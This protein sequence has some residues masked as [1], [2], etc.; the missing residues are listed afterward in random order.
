MKKQSGMDTNEFFDR[1]YSQDS[2][3]RGFSVYNSEGNVTYKAEVERMVY[4]L[5]QELYPTT[6]PTPALPVKEEAAPQ[7]KPA[8]AK[9]AGKKNAPAAIILIANLIFLAIVAI[10]CFDV[11]GKIGC[12]IAPFYK[13]AAGAC[14]PVSIL[15]GLF[16]QLGLPSQLDYSVQAD[17]VDKIFLIV[18]AVTGALT[19]VFALWQ[20][21][22]SIVCLAQKK[23]K[24]IRFGWR[25]FL[26]L[27]FLFGVLLSV[28]A[29]K[30]QIGFGDL[31]S[32]ILPKDLGYGLPCEGE[33][34][35][36]CGGYGLYGL[37]VLPIITMICSACIYKKK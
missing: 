21:I 10:G 18:F 5:R 11:F 3:T 16:A 22:A 35:T 31:C 9:V 37:I 8:K 32:L 36:L 14:V 30:A 19:V 7:K 24:K 34:F 4:E 23:V 20:V 26:M 33:G 1:A 29:L 27:I 25:A 28:I 17:A 12:E 6:I 15:D 2:V 13:D